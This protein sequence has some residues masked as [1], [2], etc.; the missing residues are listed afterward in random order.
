MGYA[1][2]ASDTRARSR[3]AASRR[4]SRPFSEPG[5][6]RGNDRPPPVRRPPR[7]LSAD[8]VNAK[9]ASARH[10]S[11]VPRRPA[12]PEFARCSLGARVR[13]GGPGFEGSATSSGDSSSRNPRTSRPRR[14]G[15]SKIDAIYPVWRMCVGRV[16]ASLSG[17]GTSPESFRSP[18]RSPSRSRRAPTE[19]PYLRRA[20]R[21][22]RRPNHPSHRSPSPSPRP[23]TSARRCRSSAVTGSSR[24]ATSTW[25]IRSATCCSDSTRSKRR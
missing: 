23:A 6:R 13:T 11:R 8:V 25:R 15:T 24:T 9:V 5:C 1:A 12:S 18:S 10:P 16:A 7:Q 17:C 14:F 3:V 20:D 2:P 21:T 19:P 22:P 4:G